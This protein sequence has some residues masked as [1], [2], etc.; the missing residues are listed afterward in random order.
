LAWSRRQ[1]PRA[2]SA[3]AST[4]ADA[5][6]AFEQAAALRDLIFTIFVSIAADAE[7]SAQ[8]LARLRDD[9]AEALA[10]ATPHGEPHRLCV[11]LAA[12]QRSRPAPL[13][14]RPRRG[15][16]ADRRATQSG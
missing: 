11:D 6:A 15:D 1:T 3:S 14:D 2:R 16:V 4:P 13:A 9:E 7:P 5:D 8:A 10:Q 12:P